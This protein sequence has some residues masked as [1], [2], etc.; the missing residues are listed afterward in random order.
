MQPNMDHKTHYL[1]RVQPL[2]PK[3]LFRPGSEF[4][5]RENGHDVV[6]IGRIVP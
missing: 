5:I 1:M 6:A 4:E 3:A 2:M